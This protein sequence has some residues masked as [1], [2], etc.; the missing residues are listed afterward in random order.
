MKRCPSLSHKQ[1]P[2]HTTYTSSSSGV[3]SPLHYLVLSLCNLP[4]NPGLYNHEPLPVI[5]ILFFAQKNSPADP[6]ECSLAG[7]CRIPP[8]D[9]HLLAVEKL[10]NECVSHHPDAKVTLCFK[11]VNN[12]FEKI[13]PRC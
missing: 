5:R 12:P 3:Y 2:N 8:A 6:E 10:H 13:Y 4:E 1:L 9:P 11:S 7:C